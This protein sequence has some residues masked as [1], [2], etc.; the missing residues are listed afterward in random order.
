MTTALPARIPLDM[1]PGDPAA[2]DD[3]VRSVAGAAHVLA[4]LAGDLEGPAATAPGWIGDDAAA[5][6]AQIGRVRHLVREVGGAVLVATGHLSAH[7]DRLRDARRQ[8]RDLRA[9]QD[10]DH[11]VAW[12][13]WSE[14]EVIRAQVQYDGAGAVAVVEDLRASEESRRRRHEALLADVEDDAS[15]T[16]RALVDA[17]AVVGGT[18]RPGDDTR[19]L[20]HLA[21]LLPFWGD[22]QL[23]ASG[24]ALATALFEATTPAGMEEAARQATASAGAPPFATAFLEALGAEGVRALL[25]RLGSGGEWLPFLA[26]MLGTALGAAA[27]SGEVDDVLGAVYVHTDERYG[28]S[29]AVAVGMAAVVVAGRTGGSGG[30]RPA[31]VAGWARQMLSREHVQGT[32]VGL[33]D[34]PKGFP[35]EASDPVGQMVGLLADRHDSAASAALL[36]DGAVWEA[37]LARGWNDGGAALGQVIVSAALQAGEAGADAVRSGLDVIGSSLFEGSPR[38]WDVSRRTVAQV[39]A[40]IGRAVASQVHVA[41]GALSVGVDGRLVDRQEE[42]LRGIGYV[43]LDASAAAAIG[44]ALQRSLGVVPGSSTVAG[45]GAPH[46]VVVLP[47]AFLAVREYGH[48]LNHALDGFEAK[49]RAENVELLWNWTVGLPTTV[50]GEL[51]RRSPVGAALSFAEGS[52]AILFGADGTWDE[53]V[54]RGLRFSSADAAEEARVRWELRRDVESV[55]RQ[56]EEAFE[57]TG[58][59]LGIPAAPVSPKANWLDPVVDTVTGEVVSGG[60]RTAGR[61]VNDVVQLLR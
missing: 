37:A 12:G 11:A 30:P 42:V 10:D 36:G 32:D 22:P 50:G 29:D 4:V 20:A 35:P 47:A 57:R 9:E 46:P 6:A 31:T 56:A 18:G 19:A 43:S 17:C 8:V 1:P 21:A 45:D 48:R 39:A 38:D 52:A 59:A 53:P 61:G 34:L 33:G 15:A 3:V 26:T 28:D 5:A 7:A 27:G 58:A 54:D 60:L 44:A 24:A 2:I 49:Q 51:V 16:A 13:R 14:L 23:A 25:S 55:A 41:A 40:D